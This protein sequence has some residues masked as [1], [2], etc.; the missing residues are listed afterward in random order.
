MRIVVDAMGSDTHPGPDVAGGVM[1]ARIDAFLKELETD[2]K[3]RESFV[4]SYN[5]EPNLTEAFVTSHNALRDV[6]GNTA[7]KGFYLIERF[8]DDPS[9]M[10]LQGPFTKQPTNYEFISNM[11]KRG[12]GIFEVRNTNEVAL[13]EHDRDFRYT[14]PLR[15]QMQPK[16]YEVAIQDQ[17]TGRVYNVLVKAISEDDARSRGVQTVAQQEQLDQSR[18]I[19][20]EPNAVA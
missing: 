18:L 4:D 3:E 19:A 16:P 7:P 17:D 2:K 8:E 15:E 20:V 5:R 14:S 1:A 11:K 13:V 10:H 6:F 9:V 12:C